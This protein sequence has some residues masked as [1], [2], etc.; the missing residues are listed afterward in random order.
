MSNSL[1]PNHRPDIDLNLDSVK[2]CWIEL[3]NGSTRKKGIIIGCIYRHPTAN[4]SEFSSKLEETIRYLNTNNYEVYILGDIDIIFLNLDKHPQTED[5]IDMLYANYCYPIIT[6]PT[7]ITNH[8]AT[9][10]DHIYTNVFNST[11]TSGILTANV[12]DHL[13]DHNKRLKMYL[14]DAESNASNSTKT[15]L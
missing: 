2:S 4:F 3:N 8:S 10:I 1:S 7:R 12:S 14:K 15:K 6:K 9:L 11:I 13:P 5:Y